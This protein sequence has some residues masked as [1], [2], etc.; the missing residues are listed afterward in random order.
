MLTVQS[1][2]MF[3][4]E[5]SYFSFLFSSFLSAVR[6]SPK[7][8]AVQTY[9]RVSPSRTQRKNYLLQVVTTGQLPATVGM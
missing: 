4:N 1:L 3:S 8:I 9:E 7:Y 2:V 6:A 5:G